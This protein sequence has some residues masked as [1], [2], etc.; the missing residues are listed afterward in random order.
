MPVFSPATDGPM[1]ADVFDSVLGVLFLAFV[2]AVALAGLW[3]A[4]MAG[5]FGYLRGAGLDRR[6][7]TGWAF[8][9]TAS[10]AVGVAFIGVFLDPVPLFGKMVDGQQVVLGHPSWG[11]LAF[12]AAFLVAGAV[13]VAIIMAAAREARRQAVEARP[14]V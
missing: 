1:P 4:T 7:R 8:A 5:G 11:L 10:A 9:V 3:A 12:T 14:A 6:W 2:M 13:M